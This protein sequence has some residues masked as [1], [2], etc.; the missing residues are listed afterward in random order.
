LY[1]TELSKAFKLLR[2]VSGKFKSNNDIPG[3]HKFTPVCES[4][5]KSMSMAFGLTHCQVTCIPSPEKELGN[6]KLL[7]RIEGDGNCWFRSVAFIV[8]GDE[9]KYKH[10]RDTLASFIALNTNT[11]GLED[12]HDSTTNSSTLNKLVQ[13]TR[14]DSGN[15][16]TWG[17][18]EHNLALCYMLSTPVFVNESNTGW[19][20]YCP[21]DLHII[22]RTNKI[23]L[24]LHNHHYE[25]VLDV[26]DQMAIKSSH[27]YID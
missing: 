17:R 12:W 8:C 2:K 1:N 25:P 23:Y 16:D 10:I 24:V 7:K 27:K 6:P 11:V 3:Q 9:N 4:W 5:K 21:T 18:A 20:K 13:N 26:T 14:S 22:D 15:V 19:T